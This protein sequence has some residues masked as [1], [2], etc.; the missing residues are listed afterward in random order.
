[1]KKGIFGIPLF[2]RLLS[3]QPNKA[4]IPLFG[5]QTKQPNDRIFPYFFFIL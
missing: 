1:M 2:E 3:F 4:K 5:L